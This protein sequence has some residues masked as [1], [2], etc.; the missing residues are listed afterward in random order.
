MPLSVNIGLHQLAA[1]IKSSGRQLRF[2]LVG[3]ASAEPSH[4]R[5]Y[6]RKWLDDGRAG[7]MGWLHKRFDERTD[8]ATYLPGAQ[9]VIC[10][11]MNYHVPL[12]ESASQEHQARIA[13]YALGEDYH[14]VLKK[15]LH[16]LADKVRQLAP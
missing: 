11:A 8:P 2:D 1:E 5:D 12:E 3:I 9:S 14:E 6:F 4:Y 13:R 7:S 16:L 15:R 10:V